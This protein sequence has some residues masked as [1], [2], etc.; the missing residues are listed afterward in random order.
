[1]IVAETIAGLGAAKTAFDMARG[2]QNIHDAAARDRAV[3]DLQKEILTAQSAQ[4]TLL[5]RVRELEKEVDRLKAWDADKERYRLIELRPGV[6][7]YS[8]KEEMANGE[9]QHK[10]C[11]ACYEVGYKS[12]LKQETW[13]PG[14]CNMLVCRGCGW[15]AYLSGSAD[16]THKGLRPT[17][18][19]GE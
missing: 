10:L 3:I 17:P 9:P 14:R 1:M 6:V 19:R 13:N 7:A 11:T 15:F 16:P 8:L 5:E 4:F 2:L 18:Y 12:F